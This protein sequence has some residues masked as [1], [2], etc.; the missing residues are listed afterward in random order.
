M[1]FANLG[2]SEPEP[3]IGLIVRLCERLPAAARIL[4]KRRKGKRAYEVKDEYDVHDLLHALIRGYLKYSVQEEPLGKIAGAVSG[5]AD[6]AIEELGAIIEVKFARGPQD[7]QKLIDEFSN[8]L[9]LYTKWVHL[10]HFIYLV[11]NSQDL[12]DPEAMEKLSGEQTINGVS[13]RTYIVLA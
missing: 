11:Y 8:D 2:A 7:Q 3:E 9:L 4:S 12:R 13:F 1:L 6:I 5:R 10:G